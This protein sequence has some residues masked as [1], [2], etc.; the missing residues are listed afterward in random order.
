MS[1]DASRLGCANQI[2]C[3]GGKKC[4]VTR[5]IEVV[6]VEPAVVYLGLQPP[7]RNKYLIPYVEIFEAHI[8]EST[9]GF[10]ERMLETVHERGPYQ[11]AG[12]SGGTSRWRS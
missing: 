12:F 7:Y 5:A 11:R 8:V 1:H 2:E 6:L 3:S 4:L 10:L 9:E